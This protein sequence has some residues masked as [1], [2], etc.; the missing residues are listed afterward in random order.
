MLT[1]LTILTM[2][3]LDT[4]W[5]H[6]VY[7]LDGLIPCG[8]G[9][10][11]LVTDVE[12]GTFVSYRVPSYPILTPSSSPR[13]LPNLPTLLVHTDGVQFFMLPVVLGTGLGAL[14]ISNILYAVALSWY[15]YI[16]HLGYRSLPFLSQTEV[17]LFPIAAIALIFVLDLVGHFFDL[18]WNASRIMAHLY[19]D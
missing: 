19:F 4:C 8:H 3:K 12:S 11:V 7:V 5:M 18:G 15:W 1:K 16:T 10:G 14:I 13:L 2:L 6:R 9:G 17:F